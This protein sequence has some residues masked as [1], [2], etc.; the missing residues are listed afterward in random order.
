MWSGGGETP[1]WRSGRRYALH[2]A[3]VAGKLAYAA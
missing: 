3:L 1:T 2:H